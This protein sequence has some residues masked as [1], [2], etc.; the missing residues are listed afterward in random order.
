[1]HSRLVTKRIASTSDTEGLRELQVRIDR[2]GLLPEAVKNLFRVAE[3]K[4]IALPMGVRRIELGTREGRLLFGPQPAI[5]SAK[6]IPLIQRKGGHYRLQGSDKLQF[7]LPEG[8]IEQ[9]VRA[10]SD[11]LTNIRAR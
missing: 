8:D 10:V 11:L 7:P 5:D 9:R 2:F 1:M 4:L 3:R 6:I